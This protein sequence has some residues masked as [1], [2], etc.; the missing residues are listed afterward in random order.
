M[1]ALESTI[2]TWN[3]TIN[4]LADYNSSI[5]TG[6]NNALQQTITKLCLVNS[7]ETF[8]FRGPL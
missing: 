8:H 3:M 5:T 7:K 2:R 6:I 1:A 4:R